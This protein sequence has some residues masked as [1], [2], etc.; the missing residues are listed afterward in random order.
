MY[1]PRIRGSCFSAGAADAMRECRFP[2]A[3]STKFLQG[4]LGILMSVQHLADLSMLTAIWFVFLL[5]R[6]WPRLLGH[7]RTT[8]ALVTVSGEDRMPQLPSPLSWII[9]L[10]FHVQTGV[11]GRTSFA[12]GGKKEQ[13]L[14]PSE[15]SLQSP[16]Q[17][18]VPAS[19]RAI[20]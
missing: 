16:I 5:L 20:F 3:D 19:N 17:P 14:N 15:E 11:T 10:P 6:M 9:L 7:S 13:R 2:V 8:S 1:P 12:P 4:D 18:S